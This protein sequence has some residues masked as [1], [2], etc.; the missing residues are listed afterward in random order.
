MTEEM[1]KLNITPA[2]NNDKLLVN[3]RLHKAIKA[4]AAQAPAKAAPIVSIT[5]ERVAP[6]K[7]KLPPKAKSAIAAPNEAPLFTPNKEGSANGLAKSVCI[8][9]P[10]KPKAAPANKAVHIWGNRDSIT[11]KCTVSSALPTKPVHTSVGDKCTLPTNN[12]N[13][14]S[15][16]NSKSDILILRVY[17]RNSLQTAVACYH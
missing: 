10:H 6:P 11:M 17:N 15:M 9:N 14:Q 3:Q 2:T 16:G 4:M 5:P 8:T 12:A 13:K 7:A 1:T